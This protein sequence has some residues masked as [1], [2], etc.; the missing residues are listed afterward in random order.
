MASRLSV[1]RVRDYVGGR[2]TVALTFVAALL[3]I[4][5]GLLNIQQGAPGGY[6]EVYF[7]IPRFV[8]TTAG[9]TGTLTGFLL[10]VSAFG[11]RKGLRAAWYSAAVLLPVT[12]LQGL[13]QENTI[14]IPLVVVSVVALVGLFRTYGR[15]D[16]DV[17]V[18]ATQLAAVAA[19]AG[20]Q[21]Y[22][23]VGAFA[24]RER[25]GGVDSLMD[26]F[27]FTLVTGSTV[28]YGDITPVTGPQDDIARLFTV[29]VILVS[30]SSFAVALGVLLTPAIEARLTRALGRMTESELELLENHVL[31]LGYGE[32]TGP[33]IDELET[34]AQFLVI[35]PDRD[36]ARNL[37]DRGVR[38]LTGDPSDEG[39]LQ[40]A[41]IAK[42]R[43]A[44]AA[45]QNDAEDALAILTA[46]QLNP[47]LRIVA[48]ASQQENVVKLQR[49]GANTVISPAAIGGRLLV[50]SALGGEGAETVAETFER[51]DPDEVSVV[52]SHDTDGPESGE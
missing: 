10:L 12:A 50:H 33:V 34:S 42:A 30:V 5:T 40:S 7:A 3:S 37:S 11:L 38:V 32:L 47:E 15:F 2:G 35:T 48:A 20:S 21:I 1:R 8:A 4:A 24:L 51:S 41:S 36:R 23:T 52:D 39:V 14:S 27:Y 31:V 6:L 25:F 49:A 43:A 18:T 46:R 19:L 13:L 28:G 45:T 16:R 9:F 29:S 17:D 44:V 26:A 22:G